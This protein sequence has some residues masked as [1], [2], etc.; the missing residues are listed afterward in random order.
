MTLTHTAHEPHAHQHDAACGHAG[1]GH[2]DHTDFFD[3]GHLHHPHEGHW[4][5][6]ATVHAT[7]DAHGHTHGPD[8]GHES[9]THADHRDYIHDGHRHAGHDGHVDE[10]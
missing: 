3:G 9:V 6:R 5:E 1:V 2:D 10:H 4:D 7:H 8:C